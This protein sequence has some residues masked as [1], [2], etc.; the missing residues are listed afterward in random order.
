MNG[1]ESLFIFDAFE[2]L[3]L[4]FP[5]RD[6]GGQFRAFFS[7]QG[8]DFSRRQSSVLACCI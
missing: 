5:T 4:G 1:A 3:Y 6:I 2:F 7:D 8:A